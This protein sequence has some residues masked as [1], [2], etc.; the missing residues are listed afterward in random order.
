MVTVGPVNEEFAAMSPGSTGEPLA[1]NTLEMKR[2]FS[3]LRTS[4]NTA[5]FW[6]PMF[7]PRESRPS[8]LYVHGRREAFS[9]SLNFGSPPNGGRPRTPRFRVLVYGSPLPA[10]M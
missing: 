2:E 7:T 1:P 9:S 3:R 6:L 10:V 5:I 4:A 8:M